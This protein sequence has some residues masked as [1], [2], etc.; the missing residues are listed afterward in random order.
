M[1]DVVMPRL[2]MCLAIVLG[3]ISIPCYADTLASQQPVLQVSFVTKAYNAANV[4]YVA[5]CVNSLQRNEDYFYYF[6]TE[7]SYEEKR[8]NQ[9]LAVLL[10][11]KG[12]PVDIYYTTNGQGKQ[13]ITAVNY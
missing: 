11:A 4:S 9:I 8:A 7:G 2:V 13:V 12:A 6:F 3:S 1:E 10:A 5:V